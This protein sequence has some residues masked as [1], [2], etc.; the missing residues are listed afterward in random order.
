[1]RKGN[2]KYKEGDEAEGEKSKRNRSRVSRE[3][4]K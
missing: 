3:N 1:M 2:L 4:V